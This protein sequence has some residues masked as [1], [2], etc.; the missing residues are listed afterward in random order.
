MGSS[1]APSV[2]AGSAGKR[3]L[4]AASSNSAGCWR[5]NSS[6]Q[7]DRRGL[8]AELRGAELA[9]RKIEQGEADA[10][11]CGVYGGEIVVALRALGRVERGAGRQ[12]ACDLAADDLFGELG[13][14][15]LL[16][17][18]DAVALVQE[19]AEVAFDRVIGNAAHRDLAFAVAGGEGDL[20]L[21]GGGFRVVV[22]ELVEVAH[23]EEEQ[24]VRMQGLRGK[25]L[26]HEGSL[27]RI[28]GV[29]WGA[30]RHRNA[31][32][33]H[34]ARRCRGLGHGWCGLSIRK[35]RIQRRSHGPQNEEDALPGSYAG[36]GQPIAGVSESVRLLG[37]GQCIGAVLLH[38]LVIDTQQQER[39]R[40]LAEEERVVILSLELGD[41]GG[42][43]GGARGTEVKAGWQ[44]SRV[45][46]EQRSYLVLFDVACA[47]SIIGHAKDLLGAAGGV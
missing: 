12:D 26:P 45:A 41:E 44:L 28:G 43:H 4:S 11:L 18:G 9:G 31:S 23:A 10:I 20:E 34:F 37:V 5:L 46:L 1:A 30:G 19:T 47:Y 38:H 29:S 7:S 35:G 40:P 8:A 14:L 27:Y 33:E 21:A 25:V 17:D 39:R 3:L 13:V 2:S 6:R 16:A 22:K 24:G 32:I 42:H 36:G 15:H